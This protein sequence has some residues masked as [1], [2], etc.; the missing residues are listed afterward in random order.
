MMI[1]KTLHP[2]IISRGIGSRI[3]EI[4]GE[5][6]QKVFGQF[7]GATQSYI[8]DLERGKSLPSVSFLARLVEVSGRSYNWIL[9]GKEELDVPPIPPLEEKKPPPPAVAEID[10]THIQGLINMLH[11]AD[12]PDKPR[13]LKMLISYLLTFL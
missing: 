6:T 12:P 1:I 4:R 5:R 9:T 7:I 10:Y 2:G 11:D 8:S 13:I 3:I